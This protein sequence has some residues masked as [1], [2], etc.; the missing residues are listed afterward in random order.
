MRCTRVG[1][2][3]AEAMDNQDIKCLV[4]ATPAFIVDLDILK[5]TLHQLEV[6]RQ[7]SGCKLLYSIKAMPFTFVLEAIKPHVDGYSVSSLFEARLAYSVLQHQGSLHMTTPG[8]TEK[9]VPQ[10]GELCDYINFNSA[11]QY[12]RLAPYVNRSCAT[13]IRVNPK[14][15]FHQDRRY[16][17]CRKYSKLGLDI[18]ALVKFM[19]NTPCQ[20]VHMHTVFSYETV[21]PMLANIAALE[22]CGVLNKLHWLN[23][24][25]GYIFRDDRQRQHFIELVRQLRQ[26]FPGEVFFEPGKAIVNSAGLLMASVID[27]FSS[28]GKTIAVLDTSVNHQPEVFEYQKQ[29]QLLDASDTGKYSA[30]LVGNTCLAGDVFGEYRF[31]SPLALGERLVFKDIG[32]YSLVKANRFNGYNFPDIYAITNGKVQSYKQYDYDAYYSQWHVE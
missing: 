22:A 29:P 32:A 11:G 13:G 9:E 25:G 20:G 17:P 23:L 15:S 5:T 16:D 26:A 1:G 12:Q 8:L 2:V 28:D 3:C 21:E 10:L 31:D 14:L 4:S 6:L 18:Q 24:G 27:L 7:L 19:N 30:I